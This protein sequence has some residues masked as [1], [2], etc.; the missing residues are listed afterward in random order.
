MVV[1]DNG[2]FSP[3]SFKG[4]LCVDHW[5]K[6]NLPIEVNS[7]SKISREALY[8]AHDREYVDGVLDLTIAN[9]YGSKDADMAR[10]LPF[11]VSS[12][13]EASLHSFLTGETSV[14]P[15]GGFHHASWNNGSGFC[16]FNGLIVAA[17]MIHQL[18][19][20]RIGI[21]D[22]DQHEGDGSDQIIKH[23]SLDYIQ[24]YT[25]GAEYISPEGAE[26]WLAELRAVVH[27]FE[28]CDVVIYQ[29]GADSSISDPL[30]GYLTDDQMLR[31]DV[32]VFE[33]LA[34][35]GVPVAWCFAGGYERDA[36]GTLSPVIQR[37]TNTLKACLQFLP[38][39][40]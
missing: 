6:L 35:L 17:Q 40:R 8:L 1:K 5:L 12:L 34:K 28:G 29:A 4:Q 33:T 38:L 9:G 26:H 37:H 30:G 20:K 16:T 14:S 3:N 13:V 15:T 25:S 18:G 19:A 27:Q 23:L 32:I 36:A 39:P 7:F 11:V 22:S 21:L 24:H 2:S 31:R 10:S